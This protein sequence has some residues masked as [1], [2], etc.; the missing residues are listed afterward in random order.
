MSSSVTCVCSIIGGVGLTRPVLLVNQ[1]RLFNVKSL[2]HVVWLLLVTFE[3]WPNKHIRITTSFRMQILHP[4][5]T[6]CPSSLFGTGYAAATTIMVSFIIN[7]QKKIRHLCRTIL[8]RI[9]LYTSTVNAPMYV[10]NLN[11]ICLQKLY[12]R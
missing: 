4:T 2:V 7:F 11:Y 10:I 3:Y 9:I 1:I 5:I 12:L 8:Y 6:S